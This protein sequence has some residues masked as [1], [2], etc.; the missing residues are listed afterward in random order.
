MLKPQLKMR[1]KAMNKIFQL[2]FCFIFSQGFA[3][4]TLYKTLTDFPYYENPVNDTYQKERCM[5][6]CIFLKASKISQLSYGSMGADSKEA[7]KLFLNS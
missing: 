5:L 4:P 1:L 3:Q 2:I 7:Q 6:D